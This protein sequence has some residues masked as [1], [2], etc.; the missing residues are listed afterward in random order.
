M[1]SGVLDVREFPLFDEE[2]GMGVL[3]QVDEV[4]ACCRVYTMHTVC[5]HIA[6]PDTGGCAEL[7]ACRLVSTPP[8]WPHMRPLWHGFLPGSILLAPR[9]DALS[10]FY[11][12][13]VT[14]GVTS[15]G[16]ASQGP[17]TAHHQAQ[18]DRD[19][20]CCDARRRCAVTVWYCR[21]TRRSLKLTS[22]TMSPSSSRATPLAAA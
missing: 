7:W 18:L 6:K 3:A 19:T 2:N 20:S 8:Q 16:S 12:M 15:I 1:M 22:M 10:A 17:L 11:N 13:H 4:R 14:A 21:T 5:H 9:L